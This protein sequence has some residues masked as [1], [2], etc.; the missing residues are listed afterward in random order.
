M[1]FLPEQ[2][3]RYLEEKGIAYHEHVQGGQ[4]AIVFPNKEL[5]PE[6]FQIASSDILVLLPPGYDDVGPDMFFAHP[7][8]KLIQNGQSPSKTN[9]TYDFLGKSWQRWSRHNNEWRHGI[10]GIWTVIKRI[11]RALREAN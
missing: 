11:D 10:D 5:P 1:T 9:A 3:R 8:I 2:D 4:K 7:P 6:I